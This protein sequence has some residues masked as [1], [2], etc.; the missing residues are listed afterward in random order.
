MVVFESLIAIAE[1]PETKK[2]AY[3]ETLK[4]YQQTTDVCLEKMKAR[5][6]AGQEDMRAEIKTCPEEMKTNQ[7][8]TE[9][10][11]AIYV[12]AALQ[13]QAFDVLHRVSEEA[14]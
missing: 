13:G 14:T 9:P 3:R 8:K 1:K 10:T 11:K 4:A 2:E 6:D 12:L 7:E 5:T